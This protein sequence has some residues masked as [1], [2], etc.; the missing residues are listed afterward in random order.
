[1][2]EITEFSFGKAGEHIVVAR[3]ILMGYDAFIAGEGLPYDV[4]VNIDNSLK[5]IQVK[6]TKQP[7]TVGEDSIY[8]FGLL[9]GKGNKKGYKDSDVDY[10]A[11][12]ALDTLEVAFMKKENVKS[13]IHIRQTSKRGEYKSDF[14]T[15][16]RNKIYE[17]VD[18][19]LS[20]SEIGKE[21]S[22]H[23]NNVRMVFVNRHR[24]DELKKRGNYFEDLQEIKPL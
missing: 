4:V 15:I 18:N 2:S 14:D 23:R 22:M 17:M 3:L 7:R 8:V 12:V 24:E 11:F 13:I 5:K 16:K 21:L 9:R 20:F 6:T 10:F 1:M 19:G